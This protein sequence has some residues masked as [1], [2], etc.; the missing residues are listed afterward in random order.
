KY[1]PAFAFAMASFALLPPEASR[2][3]WYALLCGV[4]A[5]YM[6]RIVQEL[7]DRRLS[8]S[9]LTVITALLLAKSVVQELVNGQT[10]LLLGLLL[11]SAYVALKRSNRVLAGV[12]IGLGM[13]VKPYAAILVPWLAVT[14][15]VA[16]LVSFSMVVVVLLALPA[17]A[18]GWT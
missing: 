15:G 3:V 5:V 13:F 8:V 18:Y 1:W 4:L 17:A 9:K 6:R 7:P 10:N 2:V 14:G 12:L 11:L 16:A